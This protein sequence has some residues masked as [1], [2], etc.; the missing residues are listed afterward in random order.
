MQSSLTPVALTAYVARQISNFF[1]DRE[2]ASGEL[3]HLVPP[4]LARLEYCFSTINSKYFFDG[5]T[6]HFSHLHSDQYAMFLY[7]LSNT[8][9][10]QDGNRELAGKVYYLNKTLHA[11]DIYYE[12]ELPEIFIVS[13]PV[14]TVLGRAKYGNHLVFFQGCTVGGNAALEYPEIS[15]GVG[16][17][18]HSSLVGRCKIGDGSLIS[19]GS[20]LIDCEIPSGVVAF[21]R[22]PDVSF[23]PTARGVR[24]RYFRPAS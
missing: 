17:F 21:G 6:V 22:H 5:Q 11:L 3:E 13:H 1:P 2:V 15:E 23:K 16:L 14:G 10:K 12:V 18:P 4:A 24:E 9:W 8:I 19:A 20:L 7:Y